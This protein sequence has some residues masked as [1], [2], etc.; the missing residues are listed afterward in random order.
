[1]Y[2]Q[3][4]AKK[5]RQDSVGCACCAGARVELQLCCIAVHGIITSRETFLLFTRQILIVL[6]DRIPEWFGRFGYKLANYNGSPI[7][8]SGVITGGG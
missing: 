4:R 7:R 5:Y 3:P 6:G 1:M 2:S 8:P